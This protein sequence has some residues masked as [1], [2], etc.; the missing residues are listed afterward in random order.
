VSLLSTAL[1]Q[2][3]HVPNAQYATRSDFFVVWQRRARVSLKEYISNI[4]ARDHNIVEQVV[5]LL[6]YIV[7]GVFNDGTTA[8]ALAN[9]AWGVVTGC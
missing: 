2:K 9:S 5:H 1:Q 3:R 8:N 7:I 4:I 6:H